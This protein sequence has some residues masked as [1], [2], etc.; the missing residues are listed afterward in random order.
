MAI[1]KYLSK[2]AID[3]SWNVASLVIVGILSLV[4]NCLIL[5]WRGR[6][7]LGIF[8]QILSIYIILAQ[9]A[10]CGVQ[11][12]VLQ[13]CS[14]YSESLNKC[15]DSLLSGLFLV[16][17]LSTMVA[18]GLYLSAESLTTIFNS[19]QI[20]VGVKSVSWGVVF[21][22]LNKVILLFLNALRH[23][24]ALAIFQALRFLFIN[25]FVIAGMILNFS[26]G[27]LSI[28]LSLTELLLFLIMLIYVRSQFFHWFSN[29][30]SELM[31]LLKSHLKF[32]VKGFLSGVLI[33]MNTRIDI[34]MLGLF[35]SD[36]KVGFYSFV[37]AFA[38]GFGQLIVAMRRNIDPL[39][40]RYLSQKDFK[41][42]GELSRKIRQQFYPFMLV[43]GVILIVFFPFVLKI[44]GQTNNMLDY[45]YLLMI[46]I[47][48]FVLISGYN[49]FI[50]IFIQG[51]RPGIFTITM[52]LT[53]VGNILFNSVLIPY[54]GVYGAASA[55][56]MAYILQTVFAVTAAKRFLGVQL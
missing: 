1:R 18:I 50:G 22:C 29:L 20:S 10:V 31:A 6:A 33:E 56:A 41:S 9:V 49:C 3:F 23:M 12:S 4:L 28:A 26:H 36:E 53:G 47:G 16:A 51:G 55:T 27:H 14:W 24:K 38:E 7:A 48:G 46:L 42:I 5:A 35:V 11:F 15:R 19:P 37:A 2:F 45:I 44:M 40:G 32:G 52:L 17:G 13:Q 8:N 25:L 43:S 39:L 21:F 54:F 30:S 34:L